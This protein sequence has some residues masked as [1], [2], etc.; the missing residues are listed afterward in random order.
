MENPKFE[1]I[2][3]RLNITGSTLSHRRNRVGRRER[4]KK[5]GRRRGRKERREKRKTGGEKFY[6]KML[7]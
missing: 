3:G 2:L 1:V 6:G 4:R 7:M 5:K